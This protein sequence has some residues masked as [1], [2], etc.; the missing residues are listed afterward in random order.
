MS[1]TRAAIRRNRGLI[2]AAAVVAL[3][4]AWQGKSEPV[5][6]SIGAAHSMTR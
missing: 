6:T 4:G 3:L 5:Y 2:I 1:A